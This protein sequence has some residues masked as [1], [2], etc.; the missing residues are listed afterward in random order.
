MHLGVRRHPSALSL[1]KAGLIMVHQ[2]LKCQEDRHAMSGRDSDATGRDTGL[3]CRPARTSPS[4]QM[5]ISQGWE[6]G[7]EQIRVC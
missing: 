2:V 3:R 5:Q 7:R 4:T 1:A 6:L